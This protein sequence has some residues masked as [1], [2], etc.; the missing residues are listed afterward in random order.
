MSG[1][2]SRWRIER[3]YSRTVQ[4]RTAIVRTYQTQEKEEQKEQEGV[5]NFGCG[6]TVGVV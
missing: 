1:I 6:A 5:Y 4:K 2:N 3:S